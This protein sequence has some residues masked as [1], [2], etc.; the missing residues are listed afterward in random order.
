MDITQFNLANPWRTGM[1]WEIP[2]IRR[3]ILKEIL[4]WID[5][6]EILVLT[7]ARQVGKTS[8]VY[9]LI[10]ELLRR[11]AARPQDL[12]FFNLDLAGFTDFFADQG[13]FLRFLDPSRKQ[14]AFLFVDEVQRLK[15]P[16]VFFKA[17]HDLRI[18]IKILLTG[19]STLDIKVKTSEALTGRKQVFPVAPLSFREYLEASGSGL[20]LT[21]I[22]QSDYLHYLNLLNENLERYARFG[23][24]PAVALTTETEKKIQRLEEIYTS[25]LE[26][27]ISGFLRIENL[28][29]FRKLATLIAGQQ[30]ALVN[31]QELSG[32]LG[33]H[34]DTVARYLDY[35][36]ATFITTTV[37][38][39]FSNP[40]SELSKMPKI[41]LTDP[42]LRN[43]ALGTLGNEASSPNS[44]PAMEGLALNA[45]V[46]QYTFGRTVHFWRTTSGAEVDFVIADARPRACIEVKAGEMKNVKVSRGYRSFLDK[47]APSK[48]LVLNRNLWANARI[49]D[50][51]VEAMPSALFLAR[52][53][54]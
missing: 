31:I 48:A 45:L 41:Y 52:K 42:G 9:L 13:A 51:V 19:S 4:Q 20:P 46:H 32:T 24:Y 15:D 40:R 37:R 28:T 38:P 25:Y 36:E 3:E 53:T 12:F 44:G 6:P 23:G 8:I 17:I 30:G 35:L 29:A 7:G 5:E 54:L 16:G 10:D 11:G 14:R 18:P 21:E 22:D 27:D 1:K 26:K 34:R 49:G 39:F 33:I 43:L 2:S 50:A 47:Y